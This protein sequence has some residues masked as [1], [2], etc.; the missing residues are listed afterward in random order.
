MVLDESDKEWIRRAISQA[1][2]RPANAPA[3]TQP[4]AKQGE[5]ALVAGVRL[6]GT[7]LAVLMRLADITVKALGAGVETYAKN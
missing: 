3:T 6:G 1:L 2:Q 5:A 7:G 4:L